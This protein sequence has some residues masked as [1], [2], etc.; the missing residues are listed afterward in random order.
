M[1][2]QNTRSSNRHMNELLVELIEDGCFIE[3][4]GVRQIIESNKQKYTT[5]FDLEEVGIPS[6]YAC[7]EL[8]SLVELL[9]PKIAIQ[10]VNQIQPN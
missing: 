4:S 7:K 2:I 8:S 9:K 10:K 6:E 1:V 3:G 5:K